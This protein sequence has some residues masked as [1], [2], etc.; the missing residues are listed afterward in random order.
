[1][2][3]CTA[4]RRRKMEMV[5]AFRYNIHL[6]QVLSL[7]RFIR[8]KRDPVNLTMC[9]NDEQFFLAQRKENS[10]LIWHWALDY[11]SSS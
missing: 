11:D 6:Q 1:M 5:A 3:Q 8:C 9:Y 10:L 4:H 2:A 7:N